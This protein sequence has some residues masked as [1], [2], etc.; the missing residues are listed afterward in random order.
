MDSR[1]AAI[2]LALLGS[3]QLTD[4]LTTALDHARGAVEEMPVT[5]GILGKGGLLTWAVLKLLLVTAAGIALFLTFQWSR[6]NADA[7]LLHRFV[8]NSCRIVTVAVAVVSLNNAVLF[9]TL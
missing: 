8:L 9:A 7:V 6:R 5:A 2:W 4:I 3:I 1:L